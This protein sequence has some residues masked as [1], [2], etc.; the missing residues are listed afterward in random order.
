M[1]TR[2]KE[3]NSWREHV[4]GSFRGGGGVGR[5]NSLH[6]ARAMAG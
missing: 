1:A 6:I 5:A 4:R 2:I 3:S